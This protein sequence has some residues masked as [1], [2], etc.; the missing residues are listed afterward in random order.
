MASFDVPSMNTNEPVESNASDSVDSDPNVVGFQNTGI[1]APA[2]IVVENTPVGS[3][4][5][6]CN[7]PEF[8]QAFSL[9]HNRADLIWNERTR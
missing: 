4:R 7:W 3:G 5:L 2:Q 9:D 6:L 8:W 1:P